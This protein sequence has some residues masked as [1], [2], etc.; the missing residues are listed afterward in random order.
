RRVLLT[1]RLGHAVQCL[2]PV[3]PATRTPHF[4][5]C[6]PVQFEGARA[7]ANRD[8]RLAVLVEDPDPRI[9][10]VGHDIERSSVAG[11]RLVDAAEAAIRFAE[12]SE[13]LC[14]AHPVAAAPLH[15]DRSLQ[16][17][18]RCLVMSHR[19]MDD[20]EFTNLAGELL[21]MTISAGVCEGTAKVRQRLLVPT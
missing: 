11:Q 16:Q 5:Q 2:C 17:S 18:N 19:A 21:S 12:L 15:R 1:H 8:E 9:T 3:V 14:R 10:T 4:D 13:R 6:L 20:T 7:I